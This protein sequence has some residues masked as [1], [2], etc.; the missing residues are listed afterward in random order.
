MYVDVDGLRGLSGVDGARCDVVADVYR[1][2]PLSLCGVRKQKM[3]LFG[4]NFS[5][6]M[7]MISYR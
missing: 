5:T 4:G 2:F 7:M 1:I 6:S 3:M